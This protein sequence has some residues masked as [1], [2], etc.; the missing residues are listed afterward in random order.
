PGA[1]GKGKAEAKKARAKA[2]AAPPA[3]SAPRSLYLAIGHG[4]APD[5][6]WQPGAEHPGSGAFEVDAAQIMVEAMT[7]VLRDVPGLE[8]HVESGEHPNV[9]GSVANA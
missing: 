8:L 3:P 2:A 7:E 9:I 5:G 1:K 6:T 4:R